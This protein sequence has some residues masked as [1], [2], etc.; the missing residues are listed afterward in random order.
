MN[1]L[2]KP[3]S[4]CSLMSLLASTVALAQPC[5]LDVNALCVLEGEQPPICMSVLNCYQYQLQAGQCLGPWSQGGCYTQ[6][7]TL[8]CPVVVCES[9]VCTTSGTWWAQ[10]LQ[11]FYVK[12][13]C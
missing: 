11:S 6:G 10:S 4:L 2:A 7:A 1:Y 9:H 8:G 5:S 3:A 13:D 12:G